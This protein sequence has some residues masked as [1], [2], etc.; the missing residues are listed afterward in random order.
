MIGRAEEATSSYDT[1][2]GKLSWTL[3]IIPMRAEQKFVFDGPPAD[4][5]VLFADGR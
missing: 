4:S 5:Y 2:V 1:L 3:V